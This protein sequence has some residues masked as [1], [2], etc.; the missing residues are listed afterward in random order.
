M[1]MWR[2]SGGRWA[3]A[4]LVGC[5]ALL[6]LASGA[7]APVAA[8]YGTGAITGTVTEASSSGT[9]ITGIGVTLLSEVEDTRARLSPARAASMK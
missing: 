6:V 8:A 1:G 3:L 7:L 9:G 5:V 2:E 4:V